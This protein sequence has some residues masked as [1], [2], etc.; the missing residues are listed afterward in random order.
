[1]SENAKH[2]MTGILLLISPSKIIPL[3]FPKIFNRQCFQGN[4]FLSRKPPTYPDAC[5]T[6]AESVHIKE[7]EAGCVSKEGTGHSI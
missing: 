7:E 3:K 2:I 4:V 1:M 6:P 5:L